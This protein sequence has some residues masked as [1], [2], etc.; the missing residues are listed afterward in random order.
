MANSWDS[1]AVNFTNSFNNAQRQ[2]QAYEAEIQNPF[3]NNLMKE[4]ELAKK[5]IQASN[6]KAAEYMSGGQQIV[7]GLAGMPSEFTTQ[8]LVTYTSTL[9][10]ANGGD[11]EK[12]QNTLVEQLNSGVLVSRTDLAKNTAENAQTIINPPAIGE[13]ASVDTTEAEAQTQ[14]MLEDESSDAADNTPDPATASAVGSKP[15]PGIRLGQNLPDLDVEDV[16]IGD[17]YSSFYGG[18]FSGDD[19]YDDVLLRDAHT[20]F[21]NLLESTGQL[22]TYNKIRTGELT[23]KPFSMESNIVL[24]VSKAGQSDLPEIS[25]LTTFAAVQAAQAGID[26]GLYSA[27]DAQQKALTSLAKQFQDTIHFGLPADL[28]EFK[29]QLQIDGAL[30]LVRQGESE[31]LVFPPGYIQGLNALAGAVDRTS[32]SVTTSGLLDQLNSVFERREDQTDDAYAENVGLY[33]NGAGFATVLDQIGL[34]NDRTTSKL[35]QVATVRSNLMEKRE[36]YA[37]ATGAAV[38]DNT[39]KKLFAPAFQKITDRENRIKAAEYNGKH[40][41]GETETIVV[42]N[43]TGWSTMSVRTSLD[44][45]GQRVYS[46]TAGD[47]VDRTK[48]LPIAKEALDARAKIAN[49]N[50]QGIEDY[51]EAVLGV[52]SYL[53]LQQ[54]MLMLV[55]ENPSLIEAPLMSSVASGVNRLVNETQATLSL[56]D[57]LKATDQLNVFKQGLV[58]GADASVTYKRPDGQ[59]VTIDAKVLAQQTVKTLEETIA[60][61]MK[62]INENPSELRNQAAQL[63]MLKAKQLLATFKLGI[64]EGQSG[65]ALS[66][67]DFERL[68]QIL[69]TKNR[70][71]FFELTREYGRDTIRNMQQRHKSLV[72]APDIAMWEE[73]YGTPNNITFFPA[74]ARPTSLEERSK[75]DANGNSLLGKKAREAYMMFMSD[76]LPQSQSKPAPASKRTTPTLQEF[77]DAASAAPQ[78][79]DVSTEDLIKFYENTYGGQ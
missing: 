77:L 75:L 55:G 74:G 79:K 46:T 66:N 44:S 23:Y 3:M 24:D 64:L 32:G 42:K 70:E 56:I 65:T 47:E 53:T 2:A 59:T 37:K 36:A 39:V 35:T 16:T 14:S 7:N 12:A 51:N 15:N 72:G 30:A 50:R 40:P 1:F 58:K 11:I 33:L 9:L 67:R 48:I 63:E 78:N 8:D 49:Q 34:T 22:D 27:S 45:S 13:D 5:Q 68:S 41:Q 52:T 20:K 38:D 18:L 60:A 69:S 61:S 71:S 73:Q 29:T 17:R 31:G 25:S 62:E 4:F 57:S 76:D 43:D 28:A 21:R 54:E 10:A 6:N 19:S 26:A